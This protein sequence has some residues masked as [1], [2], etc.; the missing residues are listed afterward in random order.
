MW[1]LRAYFTTT[2]CYAGAVFM[3]GL[4]NCTHTKLWA[5]DIYPYPKFNEGLA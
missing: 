2:I 4:S 1:K 5:V 3:K